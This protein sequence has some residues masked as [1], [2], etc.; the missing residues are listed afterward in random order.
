MKNTLKLVAVA[1]I[2]VFVYACGGKDTPE[3]NAK[4][5]LDAMNGEDFDKAKEFCTK[6]TGSM[7]DMMKSLTAS[8]GAVN[9]DA[10]KEK[11]EI[12]DLKCTVSGDTTAV[13][14][15][16]CTKE[17]K[18]GELKMK[19]EG[20]KWLA[21]QPKENPMGGGKQGEEIPMDTTSAATEMMDTSAAAAPEKK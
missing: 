5:Y 17:G 7:L 2:A 19:K 13:C 4:A 20:D 15:Y 6:E 16:C 12:K 8:M 1:L 21:H 9:K 18:P 11:V 3:K 10:K 14:T